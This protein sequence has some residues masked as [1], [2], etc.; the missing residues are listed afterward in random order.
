M[1]CTKKDLEEAITQLELGREYISDPK[2]WITGN[3]RLKDRV[4]S[5][6]ALEKITG[7]YQRYGDAPSDAILLSTKF[8]ACAVGVKDLSDSDIAIRKVAQ[9]NDISNHDQVLHFWDKAIRLA[10]SALDQII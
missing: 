1:N 2:H 10:K 3:W 7:K 5:L 8:L 9:Q 4:C 6:G